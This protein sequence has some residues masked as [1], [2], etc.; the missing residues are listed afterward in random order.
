[1]PSRFT[2]SQRAEIIAQSRK[3]LSEDT[4]APSPPSPPS[5]P[6][7]LPTHVVFEDDLTKYK[8]EADEAD[9][10][11]AR[12]KAELRREAAAMRTRQDAAEVDQRLGAIETRLDAIEQAMAS[13]V[14]LANGASSFSDVVTRELNSLAALAERL[15]RT[16]VSMRELHEREVGFLRNQLTTVSTA[17]ARE[18]AF[19][20]REL[21]TARAEITA[22]NGKLDR[23]HDREQNDSKLAYIREAVENVIEYQRRDPNSR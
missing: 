12:A 17:A 2:P 22:L 14:D 10:V 16:L 8:R 4:S 15:D 20:A 9:R 19:T 11:R 5:R 1:M 23:E 7:S 18:A 6:R 13:F 3:L 21:S